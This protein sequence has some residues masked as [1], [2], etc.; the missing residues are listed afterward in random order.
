MYSPRHLA[1]PKSTEGDLADFSDESSQRWRKDHREGPPN[2]AATHP[3][4]S[5]RLPVRQDQ[6][7][8]NQEP[9]GIEPDDPKK[10]TE[11]ALV[12]IRIR[13]GHL[14]PRIQA[15]AQADERTGHHQ[16]LDLGR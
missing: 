15:V 2:A 7:K 14:G 5:A 4:G 16:K 3:D 8:R 1:G 13:E 11:I 9:Q 10:A 6:S 12:D